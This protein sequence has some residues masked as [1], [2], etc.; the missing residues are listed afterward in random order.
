MTG[1]REALFEQRGSLPGAVLKRKVSLSSGGLILVL[2]VAQDLING[3]SQA[4]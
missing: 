3:G 2:G 1:Q 4:G